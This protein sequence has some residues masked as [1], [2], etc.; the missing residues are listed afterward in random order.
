MKECLKCGNIK[1]LH[2]FP[3]HPKM[4]DGHS[5]KCIDCSNIYYRERREKLSLIPWWAE[6]ESARVRAKYHRLGYKNRN[7]KQNNYEMVRQ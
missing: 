6:R 1:E 4:Y 7:Q 3:K 2:L 5:N